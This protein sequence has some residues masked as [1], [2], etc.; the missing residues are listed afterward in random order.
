MADPQE[1]KRQQII[2]SVMTDLRSIRKADGYWFDVEH[3][4]VTRSDIVDFERIKSAQMP[5]ISVIPGPESTKSLGNQRDESLW[6]VHICLFVK[7]EMDEKRRDMERF[8]VDVRRKLMANP[9]RSG[10]AKWARISALDPPEDDDFGYPQ[11]VT[12][13]V[14]LSV[15]YTFNW[16]QP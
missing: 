2:E 3:D 11:Y 1:S 10:L 14:T 9:G 5:W 4:S 13:R 15:F 12:C 7:A 8:L 16:S 6:D